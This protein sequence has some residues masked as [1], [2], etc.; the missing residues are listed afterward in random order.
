MVRL[1][2]ESLEIVGDFLIASAEASELHVVFT[3]ALEAA[4]LTSTNGM[5]TL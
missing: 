1:L 4:V 5:F 2:T 3:P